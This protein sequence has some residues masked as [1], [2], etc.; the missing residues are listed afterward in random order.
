MLLTLAKIVNF[1]EPF[2]LAVYASS[3]E[4]EMRLVPWNDE[5]KR[6]FLEMQLL[7]QH[8]YYFSRY[9]AA[10]YEIINLAQQPIGRLYVDRSGETIKILDITILPEYRSKG[11]GGKIVAEIMREGEQTNKPVEIYVE[12]FNHSAKFFARLGFEPVAEEGFH[13]LWQWKPTAKTE[14]TTKT[15]TTA[16]KAMIN[17]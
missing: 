14:T 17:A 7:A 16:K 2:L 1:E 11:A 9:P 3:R 12:N 13:V 4:D 6:A 5:Q 8:Q 10:S 15:E